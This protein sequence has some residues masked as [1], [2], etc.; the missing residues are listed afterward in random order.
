MNIAGA[1]TLLEVLESRARE[2]PELSAFVYDDTAHSFGALWQRAGWFAACLLN[3]GVTAGDRIVLALPNAPDFFTVFY[4]SQRAGA[5]PV[6]LFPGAG[7]ARLAAI[8]AQADANII[9]VAPAARDGLKEVLADR[10]EQSNTVVLIPD[11]GAD[12]PPVAAL[13]TV[14]A[15]D[16]CFIQ[17]TSGSTGDPKGVQLSHANV[18]ANIKQLIAGMRIT[19]EDVFVTWLPLYHDMGLILMSMVPFYLG[20]RL[21]LLPTRLT[22]AQAWLDAIQTHHGTVTAAPDFAYRFLLRHLKDP[23][24]FDL[25]SLRVALNAAEPVRAQTILD[26]ER[27]FG[28]E[29]VMIA[30]YGLAE[31]SCGVSTGVPG[32]PVQVDDRGCVAIGPPFPGIEIRIDCA[33]AAQDPAGEILVRS[34]A[35]TRGYYNNPAATEE[36]LTDDGF[37]R[38]GDLGYLDDAGYLYVVSRRKDIIIQGGRNIAP[39]EIEEVTDAAPFVRYTAAVGIDPGGLAG[40]QV[41]LFAELRAGAARDEQGLP[42]MTADL[43]QRFLRHFGFRPGRVYLLAPHTIPRTPNGKLQHGRL[44]QRYL[45]GSLRSAGGILF[46][47]Y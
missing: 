39:A 10:P 24:R 47:E 17:Y 19:K 35:T 42:A 40:E 30:G 13:P 27:M 41:Y 2:T 5:V 46:P 32:T 14:A 1:V 26:F 45:D 44:R 29:H 12:T 18:L 25:H 9:V 16:L 15:D 11:I 8:A 43:V 33:D 7:P 37:M 23:G 38:T 21:I 20:A 4:G 28:L 3:Q 22:N 31:A 36:L 34:A 6:P